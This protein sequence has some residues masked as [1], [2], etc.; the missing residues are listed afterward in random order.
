MDLDSILIYTPGLPIPPDLDGKSL[1]HRLRA[2]S[3]SPRTNIIHNID[4]DPL[5]G[6]FQVEVTRYTGQH[7]SVLPR[8]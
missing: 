3:S 4:E 6:T 5:E 2:N 1:W 7:S 8:L